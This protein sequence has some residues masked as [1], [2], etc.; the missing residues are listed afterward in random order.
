V[1][2]HC[3]RWSAAL[4]RRERK[5]E[6]KTT[7]KRMHAFYGLP[8]AVLDTGPLVRA[9]SGVLIPL[10]KQAPDPSVLSLTEMQVEIHID[11]GDARVWVRQI[12]TNHTNRNQEAN[13]R[14]CAADRH[15]GFRL[16]GVGWTS[17]DSGGDPGTEASASA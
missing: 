1:D 11:K 2:W 8:L 7:M 9:D 5:H 10:D 4:A 13:L 3:E 6:R 15:S 14:V 12:F 16:R 17:A